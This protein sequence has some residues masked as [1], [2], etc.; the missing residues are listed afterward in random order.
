LL[1][2]LT[3]TQL[4]EWEAYDRLDPIGTWRDDFREAHLASLISNFVKSIYHD[5]QKPE[6]Q[7]SDLSTPADFMPVWDRE[8]RKN[9]V[10]EK[11]SA[12]EME[13]LLST[14]AEIHNKQLSGNKARISPPLKLQKK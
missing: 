6:I 14:F 8:A 2:Q 3:S 7:E 5:P 11:Q 1:D 12:D 13:Q 10:I 4:S 9:K